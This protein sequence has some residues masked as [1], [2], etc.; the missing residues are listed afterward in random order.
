M[1]HVSRS[2]CGGSFICARILSFSDSRWVLGGGNGHQPVMIDGSS[3]ALFWVILPSEFL[4][5]C[6]EY[7]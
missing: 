7:P 3:T 4:S 2:A 1:S 5:S 6:H